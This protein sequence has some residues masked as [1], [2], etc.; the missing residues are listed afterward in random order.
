[1]SASKIFYITM[2]PFLML[3]ACAK[4]NT[5][6]ETQM[7]NNLSPTQII[8]KTWLVEDINQ[9][10]IIDNAHVT[11]ILSED[12]RIS[13]K[14]GCNNYSGRYI[15][16]GNKL[17][18]IPPMISTRMMCAPALMQLESEYIAVLS[19]AE[20]VELSSI[21]ALVLTSQSGKTITLMANDTI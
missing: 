1:M 19:E 11:L 6:T 12:G 18:V 2:L 10:G 5:L 16:T 7:Q 8:N 3:C 17:T 4:P 9:H 20:K 21:G 15:L 13:G 14:S